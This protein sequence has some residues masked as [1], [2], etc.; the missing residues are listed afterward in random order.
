ATLTSVRAAPQSVYPCLKNRDRSWKIWSLLSDKHPQLAVRQVFPGL[1][2]ILYVMCHIMFEEQRHDYEWE[3]EKTRVRL[4][5]VA[6][7]QLMI[8]T[9]T[10]NCLTIFFCAGCVCAFIWRNR[11]AHR[12]YRVARDQRVDLNA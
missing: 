4:A 11:D 12:L 8:K 10:I 3:T 9:P 2:L 5:K 6:S 7:L 1:E